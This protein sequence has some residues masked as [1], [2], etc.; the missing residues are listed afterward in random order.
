MVRL[1]P[2][3]YNAVDVALFQ[4]FFDIWLSPV[5][6]ALCN[7]G[8]YQTTSVRRIVPAISAIIIGHGIVIDILPCGHHF[9]GDGDCS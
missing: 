2:G 8:I 3:R 1:S 5:V 4:R 9:G 7:G 6:F